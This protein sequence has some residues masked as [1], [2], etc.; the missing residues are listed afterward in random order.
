MSAGT[1]KD[2][3]R[4]IVISFEEYTR[5][6][7]IE[8]RFEELQKQTQTKGNESKLE[9]KINYLKGNCA[10]DSEPCIVSEQPQ[11]SRLRALYS[12]RATQV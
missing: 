12:V 4:S 5:L 10:L 8:T 1:S 6:K 7:A 11:F 2:S 9:N 3:F